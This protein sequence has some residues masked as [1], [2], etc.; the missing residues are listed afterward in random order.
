MPQVFDPFDFLTLMEMPCIKTCGR[1]KPRT[2]P[3]EF[4]EDESRLFAQRSLQKASDPVGKLI[5]TARPAIAQRSRTEI[6]GCAR[7]RW[8]QGCS[9]SMY[10]RED[11]SSITRHVS[12]PVA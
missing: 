5:A 8:A 10:D 9:V 7:F 1:N 4:S 6:N 12:L 11:E 2:V 3:H